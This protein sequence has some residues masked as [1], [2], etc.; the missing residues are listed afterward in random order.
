MRLLKA[1]KEQR[2]N[3]DYRTRARLCRMV[4][5]PPPSTGTNYNLIDKVEHD[6]GDRVTWHVIHSPEGRF[7]YDYH[8][9]PSNQQHIERMCLDCRTVKVQGIKRLCNNCADIR[10]RASN[11]KS[12]SKRRSSVRKTAFSSLRA[13]VLTNRSSY[14][15]C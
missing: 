15:L 3:Q 4:T 1:A 2:A 6:L 10:K 9:I 8:L 14:P 7:V 13:E 12:Q 5:Y 11:R